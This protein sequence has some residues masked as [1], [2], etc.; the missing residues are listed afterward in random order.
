M[1]EIQRYKGACSAD[2]I[3]SAVTLVHQ[4]LDTIFV[5]A[6]MYIAVEIGEN[7]G[8]VAVAA[9]LCPVWQVRRRPP[10][11]RVGA[12]A[13]AAMTLTTFAAY[14]LGASYLWLRLEPRMVSLTDSGGP[15]G[16]LVVAEVIQ[17]THNLQRQTRGNGQ[18]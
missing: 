10:V 1:H 15:P 8:L 4:S 12:A 6:F 18:E 5:Q 3:I 9:P 7:G 13:V 16:H 2:V 14:E 11:N 17:I